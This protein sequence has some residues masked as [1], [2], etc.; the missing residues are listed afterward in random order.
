MSSETNPPPGGKAN[1]PF[2][3]DAIPDERRR[4]VLEKL[5]RW[6]P[7]TLMTLMLSTRASA[8]SVTT[9]EFDGSTPAAPDGGG[10]P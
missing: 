4:E 6:T 1:V 5:A 8:A 10:F 2:G 9:S 3:A 7:P